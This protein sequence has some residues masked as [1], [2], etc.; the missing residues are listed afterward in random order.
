MLDQ[1]FSAICHIG[2]Q[3]RRQNGKPEEHRPVSLAAYHS[4]AA[5]DTQRVQHRLEVGAGVGVSNP[6]PDRKPDQRGEPR[7]DVGSELE[8]Q[9]PAPSPHRRA[10]DTTPAAVGPPIPTDRTA[11]R[12]TTSASR[13]PLWSS[14]PH[15][16]RAAAPSAGRRRRAHLRAGSGR[17]LCWGDNSGGAVGVYEGNTQ[18]PVRVTGQP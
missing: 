13:V 16:F 12:Q 17:R 3:T 15:W 2:A 1:Q 14:A 4:L 6:P 5:A 10:G 7:Q 8:P 11:A 18:L 9:C